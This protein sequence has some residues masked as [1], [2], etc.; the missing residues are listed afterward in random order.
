MA[1]YQRKTA[2]APAEILAQ[3]EELLPAQIGLTKSKASS[4]GATYT[5]EEGT[6]TLSA[7][8]H[9]VYTE[10]I[11]STGSIEDLEDGLR[12]PEILEPAAL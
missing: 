12:D 5:G 7:H 9:G 8:R 10:V 6:V 11:A 4:H 3:A 1:G 2:L